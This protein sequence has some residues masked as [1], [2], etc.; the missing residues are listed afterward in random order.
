MKISLQLK[1]LNIMRKT[2][3]TGGTLRIGGLEKFRDL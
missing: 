3:P 2:M 1:S